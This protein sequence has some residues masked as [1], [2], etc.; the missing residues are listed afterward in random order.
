MSRRTSNTA[1]APPSP[2]FGKA[3]VGVVGRGV[4]VP[5]LLVSLRMTVYVG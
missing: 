1:D 4:D 3:V 5:R 2:T